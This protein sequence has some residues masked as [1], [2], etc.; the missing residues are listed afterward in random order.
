MN[1]ERRLIGRNERKIMEPMRWSSLEE[2]EDIQ[3]LE[4]R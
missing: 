3:A 4:V 2:N 1:P